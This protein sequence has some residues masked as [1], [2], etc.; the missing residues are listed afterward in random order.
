MISQ[1]HFVKIIMFCV[2]IFCLLLGSCNDENDV[3]RLRW[4]GVTTINSQY[5]LS[6]QFGDVLD[7]VMLPVLLV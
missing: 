6:V 7:A 2:G 3:S 1:L 4:T 5:E